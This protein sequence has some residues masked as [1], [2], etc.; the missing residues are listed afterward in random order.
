[1][2]KM[3]GNND[4]LSVYLRYVDTL[5]RTCYECKYNKK[6][7]ELEKIGLKNLKNISIKTLTQLSVNIRDVGS[8]YLSPSFWHKVKSHRLSE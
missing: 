1:M 8:K 3:K 6:K 7:N 4:N 5:L 2:F